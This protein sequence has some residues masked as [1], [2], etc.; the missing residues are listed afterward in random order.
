MTI[1]R[2][3]FL[4]AGLG[5]AAVSGWAYLERNRIGRAAPVLQAELE[6]A[7]L[8]PPE[9]YMT[10]DGWAAKLVTA[11]ESQIG[12][13]VRYDP[14]YVRISYPSGD[15]PIERGVCTD[16]IVRAYRDAFALDLQRAVHE[17]MRRD[18]AAYPK[19][20]K[21]KKPD[22]NIDHRRVPNLV[23]YFSRQGASLANSKTPS[24]YLPGDVVAYLFPRARTHI[25]I[26][27]DRAS[28]DGKRPLI[29]HN[30]GLGTR[31]NDQLFANR[32][33]GHFR[34]PPPAV[35]S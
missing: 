8:G 9:P 10:P 15:I 32:I 14:A 24:D 20:W 35:E 29:I 27:S 1:K 6:Q 18:F 23:T 30:S 2:R 7:V 12:K 5:F 28:R 16:V 26:V 25:A 22:P 19:L 4:A 3:S 11:A 34:F 33:I 13:T 17:D 21:L 31:R